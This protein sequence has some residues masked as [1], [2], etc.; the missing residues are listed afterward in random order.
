MPYTDNNTINLADCDAEELW[1][2]YK[3]PGMLTH[4][5]SMDYLSKHAGY[6]DN[7]KTEND[8]KKLSDFLN[9][10]DASFAHTVSLIIAWNLTAKDSEDI[11]PVPSEDPEVWK[12]V[13]EF[14]LQSIVSQINNDPTTKSFLAR[15]A[16]TQSNQK[17]DQ[18]IP[19]SNGLGNSLPIVKP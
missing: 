13:R 4:Q 6:N 17:I 14:Y 3:R 15:M 19:E 1:V 9:D 8:Y 7:I 11:L 16:Q 5:E 2:T 10:I 12:Q 18:G